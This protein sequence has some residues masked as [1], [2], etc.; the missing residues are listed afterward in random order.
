[1]S[2]GSSSSI[3]R[4]PTRSARSR[5]TA[6]SWA[7]RSPPTNRWAPKPALDRAEDPRRRDA[8]QPL[9][10]AWSRR[11][12]WHLRPAFPLG[13]RCPGNL[14]DTPRPRC[15]VP[16]C[17]QKRAVGN[18]SHL[19]RFGGQPASPRLALKGEKRRP[20]GPR[21]APPEPRRA[22]RARA[23][24]RQSTGRL[25][26]RTPRHLGSFP[27]SDQPFQQAAASPLP[28]VR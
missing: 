27:C 8:R 23:G 28:Q 18:V 4:S 2:R 5:S 21:R 22:V 1:M 6:R 12:G 10:A 25:A 11:S 15:G 13:R 24:R 16:G 9:H 3:S 7:L 14:R 26:C 19:Q 20:S 17:P